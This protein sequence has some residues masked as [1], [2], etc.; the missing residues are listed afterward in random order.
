MALKYL[1]EA[2]ALQDQIDLVPERPRRDG[3]RHLC[4]AA[5]D[6]VGRARAEQGIA[7]QHR[8]PH[9]RLAHHE[10]RERRLVEPQ[11]VIR[12]NRPEHPGI[13]EAEVASVVVALGQFDA[14]RVEH[15]LGG[16]QVQR[17]GVRHD[18]VEV[19]DNGLQH[20][21]NVRQRSAGV[22]SRTRSPA[23]TGTGRRF[24]GGGYG[25]SYFGL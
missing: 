2:G 7:R 5:P 4:R 21:L 20:R 13:V 18:A 22:R 6:A 9:A 8:L 24:S 19:E 23:R 17:F 14:H 16:A 11:V 15:G 25:Q 10:R 12:R 1:A 3:Q